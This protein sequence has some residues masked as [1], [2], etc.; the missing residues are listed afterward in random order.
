MAQYAFPTFHLFCLFQKIDP[1]MFY[2][3]SRYVSM[4]VP[5]N[6]EEEILSEDAVAPEL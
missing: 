6:S 3:D 5:D 4:D 2:G 1:K